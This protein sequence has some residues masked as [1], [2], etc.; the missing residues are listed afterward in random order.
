MRVHIRRPG[1]GSAAPSRTRIGQIDRR[2]GGDD[3]VG[4]WFGPV[5]VG[6]FEAGADGV[7]ASGFDD[8]S[9]GAEVCGTER[10]IVGAIPVVLEV[11]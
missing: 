8:A 10:F 2:S 5:Q 11:I 6:A 7:Y 3:C 4:A 1:A 9:G